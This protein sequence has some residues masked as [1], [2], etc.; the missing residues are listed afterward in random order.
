MSNIV[1]ALAPLLS[2]IA[3]LMIVAGAALAGCFGY[4]AWQVLYHPEKVT[5]LTYILGNI[6]S[7]ADMPALTAT[8]PTGQTAE[9]RISPAIKMFG[10]AY[11]FIAGLGLLVSVARCMSDIGVHIIKVLAPAPAAVKK[12]PAP[13]AAPVAPPAAL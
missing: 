12:K 3:I 9:Y 8:L 4:A 7:Q 1:R 6:S 5:T 2:V 11:L 10:L 13:V